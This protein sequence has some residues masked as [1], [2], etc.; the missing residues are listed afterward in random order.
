MHNSRKVRA[1]D[2]VIALQLR[3]FRIH[4]GL[5]QEEFASLLGVTYQQVQKYEKGQNRIS[6]SRL[7]EASKVL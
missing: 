7:W 1:T 2:A 6:A 4:A 3:V 5:S